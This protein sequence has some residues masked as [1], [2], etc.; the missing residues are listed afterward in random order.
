MKNMHYHYFAT[1]VMHHFGG[2][3]WNEWNDA[4][5]EHLIK[6]QEKGTG[7][8]AGS[9]SPKGEFHSAGRVMQT[10]LCL[11]TLEVYYRHVRLFR[12]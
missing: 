12:E 2:K 1:Q 10:S 9:W 8:E 3:A 4:M 7:P 6:T 5:R 11:L